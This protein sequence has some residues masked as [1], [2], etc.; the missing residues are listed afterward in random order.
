[1]LLAQ[2]RMLSNKEAWAYGPALR[3][4][5]STPQ[6]CP[7]D[8]HVGMMSA[9]PKVERRGGQSAWALTGGAVDQHVSDEARAVRLKEN[10][11][12]LRSAPEGESL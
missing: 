1:M 2:Q 11:S 6:Q 5:L 8:L 12:L 9:Q 4:G 10:L 3:R 7:T